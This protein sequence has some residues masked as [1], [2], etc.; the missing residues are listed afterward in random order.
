MLLLLTLHSNSNKQQ[1]YWTLHICNKLTLIYNIRRQSMNQVFYLLI[2]WVNFFNDLLSCTHYNYSSCKDENTYEWLVIRA[3]T[4][5]N[6]NRKWKILY[7]VNWKQ[8]KN[9]FCSKDF[10]CSF[11]LIWDSDRN[12]CYFFSFL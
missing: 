4:V 3:H 11:N 10:I 5:H 1:V 8:N 7:T 9:I 2:V 12:L 6:T